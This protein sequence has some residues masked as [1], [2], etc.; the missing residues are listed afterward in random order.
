M[1]EG[2]IK[3]FGFDRVNCKSRHLANES[4]MKKSAGGEK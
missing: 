2:D 1:R 4:R 3:S